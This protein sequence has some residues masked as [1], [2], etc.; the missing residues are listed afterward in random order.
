MSVTS[1]LLNTPSSSLSSSST[2]R[3][4]SSL[5]PASSSSPRCRLPSNFTPQSL[6]R[7]HR[8][9]KAPSRLFARVLPSFQATTIGMGDAPGAGMDAVQRRLMFED[10]C[11]SH[12]QPS[13]FS[14]AVF[15]S[16]IAQF[17][18]RFFFFLFFS[19]SS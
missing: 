1:R 15:T 18:R 5:P 3:R 14:V 10:E 12:P 4:L 13:S 11:V 7:F 19:Y 2:I 8:I 17:I 9:T 6:L 16:R